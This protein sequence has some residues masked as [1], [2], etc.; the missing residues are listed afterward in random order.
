MS[1]INPVNKEN[2]NPKS[3]EI[4]ASAQKALGIVPNMVSTMA[5]SPAVANAYVGFSTALSHGTLSAKV[6]EAIAL[7][8]SEANSCNYCVSAHTF[9]GGKAGL[10]EEEI[11]NARRAT[12]DEPKVSAALAFARKI[13]DERGRVNDADV[14]ALRQQGFTDGEISEIIANVAVNVFTNY[15]NIAAGTEIDFPVAPK[16][17]A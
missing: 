14:A 3:L 1:R 4:L 6:R 8:V 12:S 11:L 17:A 10:S 15:F 7:T 9:L 2:A 13:N 16:L 5:Q